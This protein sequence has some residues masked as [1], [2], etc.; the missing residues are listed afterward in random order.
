[1]TVDPYIWYDH[2]TVT[3][4]L[5]MTDME[6]LPAFS[7]VPSLTPAPKQAPLVVLHDED[8]VVA[9][10]DI[11]LERAGLTPAE[12]SRRMG[13]RAQSL[14]QYRNLRRRRPSIGWLAR[15]A[16]ICGARLTI[17]WVDR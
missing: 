9:V 10:I 3:L 13:I 12:A 5:L 2:R 15:L 11:L 14:N 7:P 1:M 8:Q 6:N 16:A 17:E 4:L